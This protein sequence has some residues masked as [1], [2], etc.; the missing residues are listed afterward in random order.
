MDVEQ[1]RLIDLVGGEAEYGDPPGIN[2]DD[3]GCGAVAVAWS[4][5]FGG[6]GQQSPKQVAAVA[7]VCTALADAALGTCAN[8]VA[9]VAATPMRRVAAAAAATRNRVLRMAL[10]PLRRVRD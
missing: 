3:D 4:G 7:S 9:T 5:D 6:A 8:G 2:P 10:L 1:S